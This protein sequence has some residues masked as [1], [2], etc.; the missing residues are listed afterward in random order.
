MFKPVRLAVF[1]MLA[2]FAGMMTER[3]QIGEMCRD[4][5][6]AVTGR[7]CRGVP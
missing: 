1:S 2:F 3:Y 5:G 7:I 4:A 6:G